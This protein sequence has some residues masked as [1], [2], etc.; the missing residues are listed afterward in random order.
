MGRTTIRVLVIDDDR[1]D[2]AL[3]EDFLRDA[4]RARFIVTAA[5]IDQIVTTLREA[6][7]DVTA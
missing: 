3:I 4:D 1:E 5:Q 2:C 7:A 6:I